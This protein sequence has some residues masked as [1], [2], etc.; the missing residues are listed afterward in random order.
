MVNF[1][2]TLSRGEKDIIDSIS[3]LNIALK[4][5]EYNKTPHTYIILDTEE[6]RDV[7]IRDF[8]SALKNI[9]GDAYKHA[10]RDEEE[11]EHTFKKMQKLILDL[12][13]DINKQR[14]VLDVRNWLKFSAIEYYKEDGSQ[15]QYYEDSQSLSGGEKAKLAYTILASAIAYQFGIQGNGNPDKSFRFA[16]VDEAFSKVDPENSVYAMEL[17]QKMQLQLM[18]VTP[19]DKIN[20]A[21]DFIHSVHFVENGGKN[22]SNLYNLTLEEY[23]EKKEEFLQNRIERFKAASV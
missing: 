4:N 16:I 19:L 21:E 20:I 10:S 11:L 6:S 12:K 8:R 15:K 2:E 9:L 3:E 22:T 18:V 1:H 13:D 17:F 5:I 14:K 7:T 23:Q